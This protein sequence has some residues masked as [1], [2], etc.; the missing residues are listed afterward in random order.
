[1]LTA[2]SA[3][4]EALKIYRTSLKTITYN[5]QE[6]SMKLVNARILTTGIE[7]AAQV[8]L[9]VQQIPASN[10]RP[11]LDIFKT[12]RNSGGESSRR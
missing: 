5:R 7:N 6:R 8:Q 1:M 10:E 9:Q 2:I 12:S 3:E 11:I 4:K